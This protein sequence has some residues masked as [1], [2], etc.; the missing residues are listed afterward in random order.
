MKKGNEMKKYNPFFCLVP[1][2]E[3]VEND[4]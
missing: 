1:E 4:G 3:G 2:M